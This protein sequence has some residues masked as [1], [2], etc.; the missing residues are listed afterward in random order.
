MAYV[1]KELKAK[2]A[3]SLK[4][5][6]KDVNIKYSLSVQNHSSLR[7]TISRSNI[8]FI[9]N[10]NAKAIVDR[11]TGYGNEILKITA[12]NFNVNHHWLDTSFD[13][14]ALKVLEVITKCLYSEE[15][16]NNSDVMSDY[17]DVSHYIDICVGS[18]NKP[19]EL[20]GA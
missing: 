16:Y 2:V 18:W 6:L 13:G 5:A 17:F 1:S 3:A 14:E 11:R 4:V 19:Y 9:G 12:D 20:I 7:I 8:D 15:Y 10:Y